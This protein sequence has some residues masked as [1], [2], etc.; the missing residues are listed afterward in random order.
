MSALSVASES[1]FQNGCCAICKGEEP[2]DFKGRLSID[3]DH[4]S[5]K[6]R[7]LLC[8]KCNSGLGMFNDDEDILLNA[9]KYLKGN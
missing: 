6:I 4:S 9:I 1:Q 3:H 5:G 2:S 7:G 8:M